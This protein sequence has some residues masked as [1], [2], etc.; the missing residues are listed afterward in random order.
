MPLC[1]V[2]LT[3]LESEQDSKLVLVRTG[4]ESVLSGPSGFQS[5]EQYALPPARP[6]CPRFGKGIAIRLPL[7]RAVTFLH[8]LQQREEELFLELYAYLVNETDTH[9]NPGLFDPI[10]SLNG[11]SRWN[12]EDHF[13]D[14]IH[15]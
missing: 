3:V 8:G 6:D 12:S 15:R 4:S 11:F 14:E 2:I 10:N 9:R 13:N 5:V 1:R 7:A